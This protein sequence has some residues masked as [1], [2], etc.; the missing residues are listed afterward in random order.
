MDDVTPPPVPQP[1]LPT[2]Q[3]MRVGLIIRDV[4]II[5]ALTF[6]GGFVVGLAA[7]PTSQRGMLAIAASNML[8]GTVGFVISGCLTVG[9]RWRHLFYV[10]V[11]VWLMGLM[12][13]LFF[14]F[15][16]VQWFFGIF[17][18]SLMMGVGGALSYI[19]HR[20]NEPSA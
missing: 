2:G 13:V 17:G 3:P 10:A 7:S 11:G 9:N 1:P 16:V 19:F 14:G 4:V 12:N 5:F 20:D 6:I 8:L 15:G 18:V